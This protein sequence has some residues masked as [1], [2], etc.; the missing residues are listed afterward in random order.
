MDG[1]IVKSPW[2]DLILNGKKTW[3]IRGA[4]TTKRGTIALI[5]S[6][7]GKIF[8]TVDIIGSHE[9]QA[10]E[11]IKVTDKHCIEKPESFLHMYSKIHAWVFANPVKYE[12]LVDYKHPKGAV[13]W[14]RLPN[15]T[16]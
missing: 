1:L 14:V 2:I 13:I 12:T 6:G 3:E 7:T 9:L 5:K 10:E 4:N 11:F 8:G 15:L 16:K